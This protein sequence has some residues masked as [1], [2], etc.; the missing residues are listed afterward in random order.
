MEIIISIRLKVKTHSITFKLNMGA[1][2]ES[3][4]NKVRL[5]GQV[6]K[7]INH[8]LH[9]FQ[10]MHSFSIQGFHTLISSGDK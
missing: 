5:F 6:A 7:S 10:I 8:G 3:F 4:I 1:R 2:V 9:H